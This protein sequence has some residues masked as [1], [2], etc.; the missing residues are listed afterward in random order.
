MND[1]TYYA[2]ALGVYF[3]KKPRLCKKCS[4]KNYFILHQNV[5]CIGPYQHPDHVG[6]ECSKCGEIYSL[7]QP[8]LAFGNVLKLIDN[9]ETANVCKE[10]LS[11]P[12]LQEYFKKNFRL[13]N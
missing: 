13:N 12:Y 7:D 11:R 3:T 1:D 4:S 2:K 8:C 6:L 9:V 5:K 10:F